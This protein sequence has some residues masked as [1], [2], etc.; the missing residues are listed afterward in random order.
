MLLLHTQCR[1]TSELLSVVVQV[2]HQLLG[3]PQSG[4]HLSA[5]GWCQTFVHVCKQS[6]QLLQLC[7]VIPHLKH[8]EHVQTGA[9]LQEEIKCQIL[10]SA[11]Q[12]YLC[13][14][15]AET[16]GAVGSLTPQTLEAWFALTATRIIALSGLRALKVTVAGW[17][18]KQERE[19]LLAT[20]T[21]IKPNQFHIRY[22]ST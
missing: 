4:L 18:T 13:L 14:D 8:K 12:L 20:F 7:G 16:G 1:L 21:L 6:L 9:R 11:S 17:S 10:C 2:L 22:E 3:G 19:Q 15:G 5:G